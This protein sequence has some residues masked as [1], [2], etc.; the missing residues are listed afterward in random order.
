MGF[1]IRSNIFKMGTDE[2]KYFARFPIQVAVLFSPS[3]HEFGQAF[4][5]TFLELDRLTG[6]QV[7]FFAV[8]DPPEDWLNEARSRS[9]WQD[10]SR[11]LGNLGFTTNNRILV[12]EI[13]RLFGVEWHYL[14]AI[15]VGTNL[16]SGERIV[17]GT[18]PFHLKRQLDEL[19]SLAKEWGRPDI[20]QIF[21]VLSDV[22]GFEVEYFPPDQQLRN[23][24]D[25]TYEILE[26]N[27]SSNRYAQTK[28]INLVDREYRI[29]TSI[30]RNLEKTS[31][32][33]FNSANERV[34]DKILEDA[35]GRLV[36][37]A[38]VATKV[39]QKM[40]MEM[41][42]DVAILFEEE[43][44]VMV[45]T[46]L[47]VGRFLEDLSHDELGDFQRFRLPRSGAVHR[48]DRDP[49]PT[50]DFS[51]GVQGALKAFELEINFSIIQA[52]RTSRTMRMPQFFTLFDSSFPKGQSKVR[53]GDRTKDINEK[54][55]ETSRTGRHRFHTLG[56]CWHI[57]K[58]M[59]DSPDES[60]DAVFSR[61]LGSGLPRQMMETWEVLYQ[62]RNKASHVQPLSLNEY[63]I[64]LRSALSPDIL[65]CLTKI[66]RYLSGK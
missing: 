52:A 16:W 2:Y 1:P 38:S 47:E 22:I 41:E 63:S 40:T 65:S 21:N 4:R 13:A 5:E 26:T 36:A 42:S 20:D 33:E 15:V 61:C 31:S 10:Y 55:I 49:K 29:V 8:L 56:D 12:R 57:T 44:L 64:A 32:S 19:T 43:S 37:P 27:P 30:L 9:W 7:A 18:S 66:K 45:E 51:P 17:S 35:A 62:L 24:L 60:L 59:I 34:N 39:F 6:N 14:P 23:R 58:A 3:D 54:C 48:E 11:R 25:R 53:A 50:I 28:F 46:S